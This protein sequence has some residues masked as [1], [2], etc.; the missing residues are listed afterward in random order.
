MLWDMQCKFCGAEGGLG[1]GT[2]PLLLFFFTLS[3]EFFIIVLGVPVVP[4]VPVVVAVVAVAAAAVVV[5]DVAAVAAVAAVATVVVVVVAVAV[6]VA[7][8]VVV[9]LPQTI[10]KVKTPKNKKHRK[11]QE[12][13]LPSQILH[14]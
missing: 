12:S 11:K 1:E 3:L 2:A 6:A 9:V 5:V 13:T 7:V 10:P 8:G 4:V 14:C